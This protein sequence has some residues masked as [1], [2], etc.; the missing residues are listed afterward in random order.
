MRRY[1]RRYARRTATRKRYRLRRRVY[2]R[3]AR[4]RSPGSRTRSAL[5]KLTAERTW[6]CGAGN[7]WYAFRFTPNEIPGFSDYQS[8][9]SEFRILKAVAKI[10]RSDEI[11]HYLT[12]PSRAFATSKGNWP[13]AGSSGGKYDNMLPVRD[14]TQ[15]RQARWQKE[16]YPN[17]T[18]GAVS[19]GFKPYTMVGTF[20][21]AT[22]TQV[23]YFRVWEGSAWTPIAWVLPA[24]YETGGSSP[25]Y[26]YGPY[27]VLNRAD[28]ST[29]TDL[30][31]NLTLQLYVKF[32]GQK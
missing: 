32:R 12:V 31:V 3:R 18:T 21:P 11:S 1:K 19:F 20:G 30:K 14:E 22:S 2:R 29:P 17:T 23:A 8:V 16:L 28:N 24:D 10:T 4:R 5:I 26:F 9:F 6:I 13:S 15:L 7:G 27:I 25:I